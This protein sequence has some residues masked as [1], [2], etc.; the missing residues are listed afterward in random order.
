ML[1]PPD[2]GESGDVLTHLRGVDSLKLGI[3]LPP[4]SFRAGPPSVPVVQ[5]PRTPPFHGGNTGSN[6]VGDAKLSQSLSGNHPKSPSTSL[7]PVKCLQ[8]IS[9]ASFPAA[10]SSSFAGSGRSELSWCR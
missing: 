5:W 6:P 4:G 10:T 2:R 1:E 8:T 7:G 9:P 3:A